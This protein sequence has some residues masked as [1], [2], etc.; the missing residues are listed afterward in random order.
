M[1]KKVREMLRRRRATIS[2]AR[3]EEAEKAA[4]E[5]ILLMSQGYERVLSYYSLPEEVSTHSLNKVLCKQGRLSLP[6][7][8][9]E[10][11]VPYGVRS[12]EKELKTFSHQFLEPGDGAIKSKTIDFVIVPGVAFDRRGARIG[13]GKG[14]YDRFLTGKKCRVVGLLFYE[15]LSEELLPQEAH[16]VMMEELCIV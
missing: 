10:C 2:S 3:R 4:L 6:K 1:K 16:D 14:Y 11:L 8:E 9:G 13:F 5:K 12:M 7:I 15:Q